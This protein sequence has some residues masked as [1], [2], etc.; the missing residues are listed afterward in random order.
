VSSDESVKY[1]DHGRQSDCIEQAAEQPCGAYLRQEH[2]APAPVASDRHPVAA[3]DPPR[4]RPSVLGHRIEQTTGFL[5][6]K[7]KESQSLASIERGDGPR[8]PPAESTTA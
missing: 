3:D 5:V 2:D 8:R 4:F 6:R 7:P 1:I